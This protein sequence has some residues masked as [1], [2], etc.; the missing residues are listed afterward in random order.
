MC[1]ILV[2][3]FLPIVSFHNTFLGGPIAGLTSAVTVVCLIHNCIISIVLLI[4]NIIFDQAKPS[5]PFEL[6]NVK[7][8]E[9]RMND[10]NSF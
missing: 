8:F 4:M 7:Q 1:R 5:L 2:V 10:Y 6:I 9:L 3:I